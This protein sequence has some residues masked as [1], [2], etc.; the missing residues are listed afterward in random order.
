[1]TRRTNARVAGFSFLLY[2]ALGIPS[3]I[4]MGRSTRGAGIADKVASVAQHAS[5]VHLTAVLV[6]FSGFCALAL[7]VTL[8]ALTREQDP[9]LAMLGLTFRVGEGVIGGLSVQRSLSLLWL[10]NAAGAN[11]PSGESAN[12]LGAYLLQSPGGGIAAIFFAFG[13]TCF[14]WLLLRGRMIPLWMAWL[15]V[16]ASVLMVV[17]L[18]LQLADVLPG[19]V[20]QLTWIPMAAFEV[21]LAVWLLVKG[22]AA[23]APRPAA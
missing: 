19:S 1:M 7:G 21:P 23:P 11:V 6:L 4:L 12:A 3:M 22:A 17:A 2:I 16:F 15:G 13:S 10:A 14:S 18:P 20:I 8:Y 9:D 5:D